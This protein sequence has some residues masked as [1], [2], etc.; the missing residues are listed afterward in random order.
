MQ[1]T[2]LNFDMGDTKLKGNISEMKVATALVEAGYTV[3]FPFG[4]NA[5]YDLIIDTG[6][7]LKTVQVKTA[8]RNNKVKGTVFRFNTHIL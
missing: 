4:D 5:R 3:S 6:T 7:E 2:K 1:S 8:N